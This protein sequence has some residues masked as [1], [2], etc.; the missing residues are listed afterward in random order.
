M[1]TRR[2]ARHVGLQDRGVITPGMRADFNLI[3]PTCVA[4]EQP[5]IVRDL[6]AGGRRLLQTSRGYLGSWVAGKAVIRNGDITP[7]RPGRLV[8]SGN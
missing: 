5:Q 4:P 6:P 8:R 2:N 7:A 1:L 3:D